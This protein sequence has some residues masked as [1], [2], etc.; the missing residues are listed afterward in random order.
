MGNR[1]IATV[2][3]A[4]QQNYIRTVEG[5]PVVTA[6]QFTTHAINVPAIT[7]GHLQEHRKNI[8]STRKKSTVTPFVDNTPPDTDTDEINTDIPHIWIRRIDNSLHA[9]AKTLQKGY[10][11]G[12]YLMHFVFNNYHHIELCTSLDGADTADAYKKGLEFFESKGHLIDFIRIDNVTSPHLRLML[13]RR[14]FA[15]KPLKLE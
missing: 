7:V 2:T 15:T 4:L 1:P 6:S 3:K 8:G 14:T 10:T 13:Q 11:E 12:R 5:W 9:D